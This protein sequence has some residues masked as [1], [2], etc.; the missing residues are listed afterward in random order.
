MWCMSKYLFEKN[1][2]GATINIRLVS[3]EHLNTCRSEK[4]FLLSE[5]NIANQKNTWLCYILNNSIPLQAIQFPVGI[6]FFKVS[7]GNTRIMCEICSKLRIKKTSH[8][9][10][11]GVFIINLVQ[12]SPNA[13]I[14]P[15]L[16]LNK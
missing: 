8:W 15:L 6:Y 5:I 9:R 1:E 4:S 10:H 2:N 11:S 14:F 13:L 7:N 12:I 16:T 3:L